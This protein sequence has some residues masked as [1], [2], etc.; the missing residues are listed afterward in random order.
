VQ[1]HLLVLD[2]G[3]ATLAALAPEAVTAAVDAGGLPG[4][5]FGGAAPPGLEAL[6][7]AYY[8]SA[9]ERA[10]YFGHTLPVVAA[11]ARAAAVLPPL[12]VQSAGGIGATELPNWHATALVAAMYLCSLPDAVAD[13]PDGP[14][15]LRVL[16]ASA[17]PAD[18][19]KLAA[20]T[21]LFERDPAPI[22][23]TF[24][25]ERRVLRRE[26]DFAATSQVPTSS[27]HAHAHTR[28]A[29]PLA[30]V[31]GG[32]AAAALFCARFR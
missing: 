28:R 11:A 4:P 14:R 27:T 2:A 30:D 13:G 19:A 20:V 15:D 21:R 9:A 18:V 8:P 3:P 10:A 16:W 17:A 26:C 32:G 24:T 7:A 12:A 1:R 25:A 29:A 23:G 5:C 22:D 31:A 6:L